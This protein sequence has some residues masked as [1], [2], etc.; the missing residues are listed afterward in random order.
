MQHVIYATI[1]S[2][3]NIHTECIKTND[4]KLK[5]EFFKRKKKNVKKNV[6]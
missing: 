1:K 6:Y 5:D 2:G 3:F 4:S